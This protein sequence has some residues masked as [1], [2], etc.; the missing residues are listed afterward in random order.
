MKNNF[1]KK[2]FGKEVVTEPEDIKVELKKTLT[3]RWIKQ[4]Q[5]QKLS[6]DE[7]YEQ[8][9][10]EAVL[11]I[12][13]SWKSKAEYSSTF[14]YPVEEATLEAY[15]VFFITS[16]LRLYSDSPFCVLNPKTGH[17]CFFSPFTFPSEELKDQYIEDILARLPEGTTWNKAKEIDNIQGGATNYSFT[18]KL[19]DLLN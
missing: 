5:I 8:M 15:S 6:L 19:T 12:K 7:L 9:V 4:R 13:D 11:V 10:E 2:L 1:F 17:T 14:K 16:D 18:I 3:Y